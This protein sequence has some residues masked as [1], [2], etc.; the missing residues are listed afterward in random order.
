M[1][2]VAEHA[3]IVL[4]NIRSFFRCL[5]IRIKFIA[6][7]FLGDGEFVKFRCNICGKYS[8]S[9]KAIVCQRES[10]S[11]Y[12]CGSTLRFRSI[13]ACLSKEIY[14]KIIPLL[15]FP[16]NKDIKG[17][18]M[19]DANIYARKMCE[20]LN[21]SNTFYHKEPKLDI[22]CADMG[23]YGH[24]DFVISSDVF[25]HIPPPIEIGFSNLSALL[26]DKGFVIFSVPYV[27]EGKTREHF[28]DL[29]DYQISKSLFKNPVLI[30]RTRT[31][32]TQVYSNLCFH[33]GWGATLEMRVFSE[34]SLREDL[35]KG[36]FRSVDLFDSDYPEF[37]I[38]NTEDVALMMV[39]RK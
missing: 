14:G 22:M 38:F 21:Y 33:G 31:G 5:L 8:N 1:G 7:M 29:H 30:N 13:I 6:M 12:H 39:L 32:E 3:Y 23:G 25:E 24:Y 20:K 19:S 34:S 28:P 4:G 27:K 15:D 9:P 17:I 2:V 10:R 37:G 36:G 35:K 16:K 18:G 26:S 11:C